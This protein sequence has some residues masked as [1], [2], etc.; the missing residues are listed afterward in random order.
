MSWKLE[1]IG[2]HS[3]AKSQKAGDN[4]SRIVGNEECSK[5]YDLTMIEGE[6]LRE[7]VKITMEDI[8]DEIIY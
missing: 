8:K 3:H 1:S 7:N 4:W 2:K 5:G 6:K